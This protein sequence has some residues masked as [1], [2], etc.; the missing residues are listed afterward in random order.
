ML[1]FSSKATLT[2]NRH[3]FV[4]CYRFLVRTYL[5]VF[6][7]FR[8]PMPLTHSLF[9]LF[10]KQIE[11]IPSKYP[12]AHSLYHGEHCGKVY[13]R[14]EAAIISSSAN[15][16]IA[17]SNLKELTDEFISA[18]TMQPSSIQPKNL[19]LPSKDLQGVL[20]EFI[21]LSR[22][23]IYGIISISRPAHFIYIYVVL[24]LRQFGTKSWKPWTISLLMEFTSASAIGSKDPENDYSRTTPLE[25]AENE[26]RKFELLFYLIREPIYSQ[27][28]K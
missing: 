15:S 16:A 22:P 10:D 6:T 25:M 28:S 27:L 19:L 1:N 24:L 3:L 13:A 4:I 20:G 7:G 8:K 12:A 2:Q 11:Q 18:R 9:S 23:L 5:F 21:Y 14:L 17:T 26:R